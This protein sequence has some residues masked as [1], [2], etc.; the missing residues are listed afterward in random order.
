MVEGLLWFL[1]C[2]ALAQISPSANIND[3]DTKKKG[4][5]RRESSSS[6]GPSQESAEGCS[7]I[8]ICRTDCKPGG[9]PWHP[10]LRVPA[11][12]GHQ[13]ALLATS[14]PEV[15]SI[16]GEAQGRTSPRSRTAGSPPGD[17]AVW[18]PL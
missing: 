10:A 15:Q 18:L 17:G 13:G 12:P 8:A 7:G 9:E 1:K 5:E 2:F 11:G 16:S 6:A 14:C 4:K 3:K